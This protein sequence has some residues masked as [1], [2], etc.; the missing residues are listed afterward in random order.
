MYP[1]TRR[2]YLGFI[3]FIVGAVLMNS[4]KVSRDCVRL[5]F[6]SPVEALFGLVYVPI[7]GRMMFR[8]LG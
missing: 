8:F 5:G 3:S 4:L 7:L 2:D 1:R 6:V